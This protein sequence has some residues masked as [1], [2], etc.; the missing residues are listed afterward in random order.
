MPS[1]GR[2]GRDALGL[3][4]GIQA[5][6]FD[7]DGVLTETARLHTEAWQR[8]FDDL[9]RA[10]ADRTGDRFVPFDPAADMD[11]YVDGKPREDGVRS[12]LASR[13]IDLPE[14]R[15]DDPASAW[16]VSAIARRKDEI[17]LALFHERGVRAFPGSRRYLEAVHRAGLSTAAVSSSRNCAEVLEAAGLSA[18]L[19]ARVDGV[20]AAEER[21]AG[22]PAPDVYLAA[23]R[24]VGIPPARAA[25][26]EDAEAG[27]EAGRAGDFAFVVGVDRRGRPERLRAA[28]AHLV[29]AD[30]AELLGDP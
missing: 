10:R 30:L 29:V 6:L 20:I 19:D 22:K 21:L 9:L 17:V 11:A 1:N 24:A 3:P 8:V 27:V 7:V 12:F 25:V 5:C 28:G 15:D 16:T 13:G 18:G 14:G 4:P 26:F 2:Q 23:A